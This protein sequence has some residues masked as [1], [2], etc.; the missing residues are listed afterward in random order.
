MMY[1]RQNKED[2]SGMCR[3]LWEEGDYITQ[4]DGHAHILIMDHL[5]ER[6]NKPSVSP[7]PPPQLL[8]SIEKYLCIASGNSR[9]ILSYVASS[10]RIS[11]PQLDSIVDDKDFGVVL[12]KKSLF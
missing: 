8:L 11:A 10:F 5:Q 7:P 9:C 3:K 12:F 2:S 1:G 6:C 4:E